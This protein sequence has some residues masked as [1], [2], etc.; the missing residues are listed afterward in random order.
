MCRCLASI[1]S[2]PSQ[3]RKMQ[4]RGRSCTAMGGTL[5]AGLHITARGARA[6]AVFDKRARSRKPSTETLQGNQ[7]RAVAAEDS[8]Q[9]GST[10]QQ[11]SAHANTRDIVATASVVSSP[12]PW[13][14]RTLQYDAAKVQNLAKV[15]AGVEAATERPRTTASVEQYLQRPQRSRCQVSTFYHRE[16]DSRPTSTPNPLNRDSV[17][18]SPTGSTVEAGVEGCKASA[19]RSL[20]SAVLTHAPPR[21][22]DLVLNLVRV[23]TSE[24]PP[25]L[26]MQVQAPSLHDAAEALAS[27]LA[28]SRL[29]RYWTGPSV[30]TTL[31]PMEETLS[32]AGAAVT[33]HSL[34]ILASAFEASAL[35]FR[36]T[37]TPS[38]Q[39]VTSR[40]SEQAEYRSREQKEEKQDAWQAA[41][42][43]RHDNISAYRSLLHQL[44]HFFTEELTLFADSSLPVTS[45]TFPR[46]DLLSLA[47]F[48]LVK[49]ADVCVD[50]AAKPPRRGADTAARVEE[51]SAES[52]K[53]QLQRLSLLVSTMCARLSS[54][55]EVVTGTS[56]EWQLERFYGTRCVPM[57]AS[58]AKRLAMQMRA[59]GSAPS[60]AGC[61]PALQSMVLIFAVSVLR[62]AVAVERAA[63]HARCND[64]AQ[65]ARAEATETPEESEAEL[66][67]EAAAPR[68]VT[69]GEKVQLAKYVELLWAEIKPKP[70]MSPSEISQL[71]HRTA[72]TALNVSL[73]TW[74]K[75]AAAASVSPSTPH[76]SQRPQHIAA[77]LCSYNSL[78][79]ECQ[80]ALPILAA[81]GAAQTATPRLVSAT[82]SS[83][84]PDLSWFVPFH[85]RLIR[86]GLDLQLEATLLAALHLGIEPR[87]PPT[88]ATPIAKWI[89]SRHM[90]RLRRR[91][92]SG[93]ADLNTRPSEATG[94]DALWAGVYRL[95]GGVRVAAAELLYCSITEVCCRVAQRPMSRADSG[96]MVPPQRPLRSQQGSL[97]SATHTNKRVANSGY[98]AA[99]A[100]VNSVSRTFFAVP[101][102]QYL[103]A[104][105]TD[106]T[107]TDRATEEEC[108]R[109]YAACLGVLAWLR[110]LAAPF[111]VRLA[112]SQAPHTSDVIQDGQPQR[113]P[114]SD[115]WQVC[116]TTS[117]VAMDGAFFFTY[118]LYHWPEETGRRVSSFSSSATQATR[119]A[120]EAAL[121]S[122]GVVSRMPRPSISPLL[123]GATA[124]DYT[125]EMLF[126]LQHDTARQLR[127]LRATDRLHHFTGELLD[128]AK[129]LQDAT[130]R[131]RHIMSTLS[132]VQAH[133]KQPT[134]L[135]M[136]LSQVQE[137]IFLFDQYPQLFRY[138][139]SARTLGARGDAEREEGG[140]M[141]P[142]DGVRE[143]PKVHVGDL[144]CTFARIH[145]YLVKRLHV[146]SGILREYRSLLLESSPHGA[147]HSSAIRDDPSASVAT[148]ATSPFHRWL[149]DNATRSPQ[150]EVHRRNNYGWAH[151]WAVQLHE[152][153]PRLPAQMEGA[154]RWAKGV[155]RTLDRMERTMMDTHQKGLFINVVKS[156]QQYRELQRTRSTLSAVKAAPVDAAQA[157]CNEE[158]QLRDLV[159]QRDSERVPLGVVLD[160]GARIL[161]VQASVVR[162]AAVADSS[163]EVEGDLLESPFA[164]ALA[165]HPQRDEDQLGMSH[166]VCDFA[167]VVGW[168]VV[169]VDGNIVQTGRDVAAEVR[170][171][172]TFTVTLQPCSRS[173]EAHGMA[174]PAQVG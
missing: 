151:E 2:L 1:V 25:S 23:H 47:V 101:R 18:T 148:S 144:T 110:E 172:T 6:A 58:Q 81:R 70:I 30:G 126:Q 4:L 57:L 104:C 108:R 154:L 95:C 170:G 56:S 146:L 71:Q 29:Y 84:S 36:G 89:T 15:F 67:S 87:A 165:P 60:L 75:A 129:L 76:W 38:A 92:A 31:L 37:C 44:L 140:E 141:V 80:A 72:H 152:E 150:L 136:P 14:E 127:H 17:S 102:M 171:K 20:A 131:Q 48:S 90:Q 121:A 53:G 61:V 88:P 159:V 55:T 111:G 109:V 156:Q 147:I 160:G 7:N 34:S 145:G 106:A 21:V 132:V 117:A 12:V 66:T 11:G 35:S 157:F 153:F 134:M 138:I 93:G 24:K 19:M 135:W 8:I 116:G 50:S 22:T 13:V 94:T 64:T 43:W 173:E 74:W 162:P 149:L 62:R 130:L 166:R 155:A 142:S 63:A 103:F 79:A 133:R 68:C 113:E 125:K 119:T 59:P 91:G 28:A 114:R 83:V 158:P 105:Y 52:V 49:A 82:A 40:L 97:P 27:M 122:D 112:G 99:A 85:G 100:L 33:L 139:E 118:Y 54:P 9:A 41:A 73:A 42:V 16:H 107:Y 5:R 10:T 65:A 168:R 32:A 46:M 123:T 128:K 143:Y 78:L 86:V 174:V 96:S 3:R 26:G 51:F 169:R 120:L 45:T 163:D 98:A 124:M 164:R 137:M 167:D 115:E 161:R 77:L 69:G 39:E